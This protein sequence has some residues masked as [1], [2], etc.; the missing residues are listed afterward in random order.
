MRQTA[1]DLS[2]N[3]TFFT[4]VFLVSGIL[5]SVSSAA[6]KPVVY[7]SNYPL[8]YFA[9]RIGGKAIE[10][11]FP[12]QGK[13]DPSFWKPSDDEVAA[14]QGADLIFLNGATYETWRKRATLPR[15]KVIDTSKAFS[16]DFIATEGVVHTHGPGKSHSHGG[17][18]STTWMDLQ[19]A[20][21]QAEEV[22]DALMKIDPERASGYEERFDVLAD[23]IDALHL[24]FQNVGKALTDT[25]LLASHPVY[26]YFSRR[27]GLDVKSLHWE[28]NQDPGSEGRDELRA[29]LKDHKA[30]WMIWEGTPLASSVS[31]L[32]ELGIRS[33]VIS[34]CGNQPEEGDWLSVMRANLEQFQLI[35]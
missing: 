27:Y 2:M 25:P 19:Q 16:S 10:V 4:L 24:E 26:Q 31:M 28:P 6:E 32:E 20:I 5:A 7:A 34:P 12:A 18:A 22:R 9:E 29:L 30:K 35:R 3:R 17:T 23:E 21:W 8:A 1:F 15:S 14:M 13:G 11:H 33:I